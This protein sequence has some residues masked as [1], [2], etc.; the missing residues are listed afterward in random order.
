VHYTSRRVTG[1]W[2]II[3]N[4]RK[5]TQRDPSLWLG[6]PLCH[7][8]CAVARRMRAFLWR[9]EGDGIGDEKVHSVRN[10]RDEAQAR[11][12]NRDDCIRNIPSRAIWEWR[13][14]HL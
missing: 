5:R 1:T 8:E 7:M 10:A 3:S 2:W 6:G 12:I 13:T 4:S 14:P 11:L 9:T